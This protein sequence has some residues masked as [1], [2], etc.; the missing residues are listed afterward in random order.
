MRKIIR[1]TES[2]LHRII[3]DSVSRILS[4]TDCAFAMQNGPGPEHDPGA[5]TFDVPVGSSVVRKKSPVG[6]KVSDGM[7]PVDMEP[8]LR[9]GDSEKNGSISM[10]RVSS[11]K[12]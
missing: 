5:G 8:A 9:R 3:K 11:K 4:E 6:D 2:D 1:L 12:K 7:T 10:N